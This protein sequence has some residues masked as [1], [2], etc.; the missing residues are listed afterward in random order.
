MKKIKNNLLEA[1]YLDKLKYNF[2]HCMRYEL[3][4]YDNGELLIEQEDDLSY[5]FFLVKCKV[6]I[7]SSSIYGKRL[8][9]AFNQALQLLGDIEFIQQLPAT[10]SVEAMGQV[11]V[12]RVSC[13]EA[14]RLQKESN[15]N[16]YLLYANCNIKLN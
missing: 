15:F 4:E 11:H 2:A 12:L 8:I 9:V 5:L 16:D 1:T 14:K 3:M 10:N 13:N 6:K 7:Y